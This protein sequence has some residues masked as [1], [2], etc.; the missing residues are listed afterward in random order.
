MN[1]V[2]RKI[3]KEKVFQKGDWALLYD[4]RFKDFKG[5]L[6]YRWMGPYEVDAVFD[7]GTVRITTIDAVHTP[8]FVNGHRLKLYHHLTSRDAFV[9]HIYITLVL[10]S[11]V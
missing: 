11:L 2:A 3:I 7:N 5:K 8:V 10:K 1:Q 4:S 9:K 6:C